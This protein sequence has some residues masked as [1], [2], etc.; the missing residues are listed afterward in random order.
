VCWL[1]RKIQCVVRARTSRTDCR[2]RSSRSRSNSGAAEA[3]RETGTVN[4]LDVWDGHLVSAHA[5]GLVR[6]LIKLLQ[7]NEGA[8]ISAAFS[9]GHAIA[10][11]SA[12]SNWPPKSARVRF[13]VRLANPRRSYALEC[14]ESCW[15]VKDRRILATGTL[16]RNKWSGCGTQAS[17]GHDRV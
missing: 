13:L 15:F 16:N 17:T 14:R 9:S 5:C 8:G 4:A 2:R 11:F 10:I 6:A 3:P 1:A 12:A 7:S